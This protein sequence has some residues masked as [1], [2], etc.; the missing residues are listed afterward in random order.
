MRSRRMA[1]RIEERTDNVLEVILLFA[2]AVGVV[3][4]LLIGRSG[5]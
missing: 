4:G 2:F 5:L 3:V 1:T